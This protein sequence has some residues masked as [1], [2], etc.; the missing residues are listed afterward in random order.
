[1][2]VIAAINS[3]ILFEGICTSRGI[4]K[5]NVAKNTPPIFP[6]NYPFLVIDQNK[7]NTK[8]VKKDQ[9]VNHKK[10][11]LKN[12]RRTNNYIV[13]VYWRSCVYSLL[14]TN[15]CYLDAAIFIII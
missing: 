4:L 14:F 15:I 9:W 13:N 1:M 3:M 6:E 12:N 10:W 5:I 7:N 8:N 11:K 2:M